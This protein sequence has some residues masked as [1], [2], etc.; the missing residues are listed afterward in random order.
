MQDI[1]ISIG[2]LRN[3]EVIASLPISTEKSPLESGLALLVVK[4]FKIFEFERE[5]V[6]DT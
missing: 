3:C 5:L 4:E 1:S 6:L 2:R